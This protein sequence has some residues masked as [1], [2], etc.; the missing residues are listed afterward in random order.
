MDQLSPKRVGK[1]FF[2]EILKTSVSVGIL[3]IAVGAAA[4]LA[5][6][7]KPPANK[8]STALI[9]TVQVFD[10]QSYTGNL[11]L[12]VS[13]AVVPYRE[14][15][16]AA[17]VAGK[18]VE[19]Y[20]ECDAGHYVRKGTPLMRIDPSTYEI[21]IKTLDAEVA[22]SGS[23]INETQTEI[24]GLERQIAI[25]QQEFELLQ[26]EYERNKRLKGVV[27]DSELD[28][29]QRGLLNAQ[30]QLSS[31]ENQLN[32]AKARVTRMESALELSQRKLERA[33]LN[34][35]RT[36]IV[37]PEDGVVVSESVEQGE[38]VSA[39]SQLLIFEDT[40]R[41]EVV[42]NLSKTDLDWIK[43]NSLGG[44]QPGQTSDEN[45]IRNAYQIPRTEVRVFDAR[46]PEVQWKG[47]LERVDG[48]GLD[49]MT[50]TIPVRVVVDSPVIDTARGPKALV[51]GMF[52]KCQI[53]IDATPDETASRFIAFPA[54]A[55]RPGN[56]VWI[57]N[58]GKL[59]RYSVDVV[60]QVNVKYTSRPNTEVAVAEP[61]AWVESGNVE[62]TV[63]RLVDGGVHPGQQ[64]VVSPLSQPT[65][66][67]VVQLIESEPANNTPIV[68]ESGL[69]NTKTVTTT[70]KDD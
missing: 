32:T 39:G 16:I 2:F 49:D 23:M 70:A 52:V 62:M 56:F 67:S 69:D 60:D 11:D 30:S 13:G 8:P 12:M 5:S 6:Q 42:C 28:Q 55:L 54:T 57:V 1:A 25:S 20:P 19:K 63:A 64:V 4:W 51:R 50:K 33:H 21:E 41:A 58:D 35:S 31:L 26:A 10:V 9:P 65:D 34:L 18:I 44:A 68:E 14:I 22:Q 7:R 36:Y 43:Q 61:P 53:E 40:A 27:T 48:I 29:A 46:H 38:I 66:G 45:A 59:K 24:A 3:A 47:I 37:A 17:E 15:K